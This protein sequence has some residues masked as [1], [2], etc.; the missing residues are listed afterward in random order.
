MSKEKFDDFVNKANLGKKEEMD[1]VYSNLDP[2]K[3][4]FISV[5]NFLKNHPQNSLMKDF[6]EKVNE[7]LLT[8]S[9]IITNK[10]RKLKKK[11]SDDKESE[12]DIDWY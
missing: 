9:E 4:G 8:T 12:N 3:E 2:N 10:L 1:I 7:N 6:M 5:D 11:I